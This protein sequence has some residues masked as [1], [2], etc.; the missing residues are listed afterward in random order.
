M[1]PGRAKAKL[2]DGSEHTAFGL[3]RQSKTKTR[4]NFTQGGGQYV[5]GSGKGAFRPIASMLAS[6]HSVTTIPSHDF[7]ETESVFTCFKGS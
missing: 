7:V 3:R 4:G 2:G 5:L 6:L 1:T